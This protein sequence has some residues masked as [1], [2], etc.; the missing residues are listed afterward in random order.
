MERGARCTP[1]DVVVAVLILAYSVP[2]S[3]DI[4]AA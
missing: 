1:A 2:S 3:P 4:A